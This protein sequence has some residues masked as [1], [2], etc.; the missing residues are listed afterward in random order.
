MFNILFILKIV[1]VKHAMIRSHQKLSN[2]KAQ[3]QLSYI[4]NKRSTR[5]FVGNKGSRRAFV[6]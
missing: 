1:Y 4:D 5:A 3:Q 6:G 2:T